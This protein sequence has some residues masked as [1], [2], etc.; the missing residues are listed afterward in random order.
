MTALRLSVALEDAGWHPASW[1]EPGAR[2]GE[3][4]TAAYW[5]DQVREAE[6]GL[7]DFVT[8]G[9]SVTL[10]PTGRGGRVRGRL[11]AVL[12]AARIAPATEHIGIVPAVSTAV[13]EPF[14]VSTQIATLDFVSRGR[15]G[16]EVNVAPGGGGY[17]GPRPV[18][19]PE[20][21]FA[22]ARDYVDVVRRLWDS[23]EDDAEIRNPRTHRFFDVTKVHHIDFEGPHFAVAGP[24]ITPRPPQ[25]QPIV[26]TA[27][28]A[29]DLAADLV[30]VATHDPADARA[31]DAR[32]VFADIIVFL[33]EE[34]GA[35]EA[36]RQRLDAVDRRATDATVFA[37]T[38]TELADRLLTWTGSDGFRLHP[39]TH[40]HDLQAITRRLVPELQARG[41]FRRAYE[42]DTLRGLLG[43]DRPANRFVTA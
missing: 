9:D 18:S 28:A 11:D 4:F 21:R 26:A 7:L 34:P 23:W 12:L 37:G 1:R 35:A 8:L 6:R 42:A 39:A 40:A 43:L 29:A 33:D 24:S 32:L 27:E 36:R 5:V 3:L 31:N 15:A 10:Q 19:S 38:P 41:A 22:E 16:W 2:A 13:T 30:F 14:L 25:G 20:A 17:V